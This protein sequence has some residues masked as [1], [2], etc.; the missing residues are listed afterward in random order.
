M[1]TLPYPST[2]VAPPPGARMAKDFSFRDANW[3]IDFP[4]SARTMLGFWKDAGQPPV[5]GVIAVD[6]VALREIVGALGSVYVPSY[7]Q[8]FTTDGLLEKLLQQVEVKYL[9]DPNKKG[10]LVALATEIE[11]RIL[12]ASPG[13][14]ARV[15]SAMAKAADQKHVQFYFSDP[16]AEAAVTALGW[17]GSIKAPP[18]TTDLLAVSNAMNAGSKVNLGMDKTIEYTVALRPDGS[19]ETTAVLWYS[20]T[21]PFDL[22]IPGPFSDYLRVYRSQGTKIAPSPEPGASVTTDLGLPTAVR[23]FLLWRGQARTETIA[24]RVPRAWQVKRGATQ[25]AMPS[26]GPGLSA[27]YRLLVVRQADLQDV[28]T[29]VVL[30]APRGWAISSASASLTASG[31]RVP[32]TV[33]GSRAKVAVPLSGDL[34]VDAVLT[35]VR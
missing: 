22:P 32:V 31:Q 28:P 26:A 33:Q 18:G 8:T 16:K 2:H 34:V 9:N 25:E 7:K 10:L 13:E 35:A 19:A 24:S 29:T 17:A 15:G 23:E 21:A 3:W 27:R 1:Y 20:N 4:T 5:D 14:L 12:S 30:T 6:T 11:R